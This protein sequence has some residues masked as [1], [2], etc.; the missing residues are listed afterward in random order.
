MFFASEIRVFFYTA[1][2]I[3]GN[4]SNSNEK[5]CL[6]GRDEDP[7]KLSKSEDGSAVAAVPP[8]MSHVPITTPPPPMMGTDMSAQ[9]GY[10]G[11][12]SWYQV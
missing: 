1:V 4:M 9:S 12:G 3:N 6:I 10:G 5:T 8:T 11:Y 2:M 7:E